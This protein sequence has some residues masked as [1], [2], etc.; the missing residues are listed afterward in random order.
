M[1][2]K[3]KEVLR[4]LS[5]VMSMSQREISSNV[6]WLKH[7]EWSAQIN[8]RE[9]NVILLSLELEDNE[10]Q[11]LKPNTCGHQLKIKMQNI[12]TKCRIVRSFTVE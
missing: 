2:T 12:A 5:R 8:G 7:P 9:V 1:I 3:Y 11:D 10:S 6:S 4:I